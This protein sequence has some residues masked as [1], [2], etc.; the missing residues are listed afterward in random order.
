MEFQQKDP[1]Q[2]T[3]RVFKGDRVLFPVPGEEEKGQLKGRLQGWEDSTL[4][5]K[6]KYSGRAYRLDLGR[7]PYFK[8]LRRGLSIGGR[9]L[10][11]VAIGVLGFVTAFGIAAMISDLGVAYLGYLALVGLAL[12]P[13]FVI[14]L[15]L[16]IW[17]IVKGKRKIERG[18]WTWRR[19]RRVVV[20]KNVN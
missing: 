10:L 17:F 18:K 12:N 14:P 19:L 9:V 20:R 5:V 15:A 13:L 7:I 4:V 8:H 11:G 1:P 2:R 3:L 6:E 16:G